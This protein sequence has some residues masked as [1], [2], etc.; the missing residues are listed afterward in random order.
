MIKIMFFLKGYISTKFIHLISAYLP[1]FF[2]LWQTNKLNKQI[3]YI[4]NNSPYYTE[5]L[6]NI[7]NPTINDFPIINKTILMNNFN[8]INTRNLDRE[9]VIALAIDAEENREFSNKIEDI[10]Y[11]LSS[12]TSGNRGLFLISDKESM[13]WAGVMFA[14]LGHLRKK[15]FKKVRI[16]FFMRANNNLYETIGNKWFK[17][18]F[19]DIYKNYQENLKE[20]ID[21]NPTIIIAQ[22]SIL[23]LLSKDFKNNNLQETFTIAEVLEDDTAK[24][25]KSSLGV[26]NYI[27]YQATEGFI[28]A[29]YIDNSLYINEDLIFLEKE[30][31]GDN[32]FIPIIT[33]LNRKTQPIIRYRLNDI[34]IEDT[35]NKGYYNFIKLKNIEGRSD[36][37]FQFQNIYNESVTIFPDFLRNAVIKASKYITDYNIY[38]KSETSIHVEFTS[39]YDNDSVLIEKKLRELLKHYNLTKIELTFENKVII[40]N[41]NIKL[42]RIFSFCKKTNI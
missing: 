29:T 28:G 41:P 14:K 40:R 34:L 37:C 22:P 19:F 17:F 32:R 13:F 16:A 18:K 1:S 15:L 12:G 3:K 33:D 26:N 8:S 20:L 9:T 11:G 25:I 38:Q 36:E 24:L 27:I 23:K 5:L 35:D 2:K 31:I 42:R 4:K 21:F 39:K 10:S 6:K 7:K 30:Y